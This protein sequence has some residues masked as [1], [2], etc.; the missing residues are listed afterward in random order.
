MADTKVSDLPAI[1]TLSNDDILY[2]G[3]VSASTSN[4]ITYENLVGS[5]INQISADLS[6]LSSQFIAADS[7]T[8]AVSTF[9]ATTDLTSLSSDVLI[10]TGDLRNLS[11]DNNSIQRYVD[12]GVTQ[13]I[14]I[15]TSTFSFSGGFLI[16]VI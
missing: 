15:G 1:T 5:D 16:N 14:V 3:D 8:G 6:S 2:I 11:E 9:A 13:D 10:N 7:F 4:K 12:I